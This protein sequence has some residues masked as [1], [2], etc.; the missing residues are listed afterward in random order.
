MPLA[1]EDTLQ[2]FATVGF[3]VLQLNAVKKQIVAACNVPQA[4]F[5]FVEMPAP[6]PILDVTFDFP[7]TMDQLRPWHSTELP[8]VWRWPIRIAE[9][10]RGKVFDTREENTGI[11]RRLLSGISIHL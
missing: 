10:G 6:Y 7:G 9:A 1:L 3:P 11:R 4:E 5:Q 8:P 2:V